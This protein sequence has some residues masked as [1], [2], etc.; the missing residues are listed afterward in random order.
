MAAPTNSD[1]ETT[2]SRAVVVSDAC[3][4]WRPI[5]DAPIDGTEILAYDE[6]SD[7]FDVVKWSDEEKEFIA[8][9]G[10]P[11]FDYSLW[12]EI[13]HPQNASLSNGD[14]SAR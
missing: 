1:A 11:G 3:S 7:C 6:V 12:M 5:C 14:E 8:P 13:P 10:Y 4:A 9:H 2:P